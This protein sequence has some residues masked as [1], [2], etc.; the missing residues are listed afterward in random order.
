MREI[1]IKTLAPED[2]PELAREASYQ[3]LKILGKA[4]KKKEGREFEQI[5]QNIESTILE[6]FNN[7]IRE[8]FEY[9]ITGIEE[10]FNEIKENLIESNTIDKDA[11]EKLIYAEPEK[12]KK[13]TPEEIK[14]VEKFIKISSDDIVRKARILNGNLQKN[15]IKIAEENVPALRKNLALLGLSDKEIEFCIKQIGVKVGR[16]IN[17]VEKQKESKI[18]DARERMTDETIIKRF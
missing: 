18:K 6:I 7:K 13:L 3:I 4:I 9:K 17:Y 8:I 12:V 16:K 2:I 11:A 1:K 15:A 5:K 14:K 10:I